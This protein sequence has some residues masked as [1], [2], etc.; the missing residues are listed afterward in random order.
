MHASSLFTV[1]PAKAGTQ[2]ERRA[3]ALGP[4][5]RGDDERER[6]TFPE[7]GVMQPAD[8]SL[9]RRQTRDRLITARMALGG[10]QRR[11][12]GGEIERRLAALLGGLAGRVVG[13]Y[14]P[15]RAEVDPRPLA[16][17]LWSQ[18]RTLALPAIVERHG[19]LE[20]RAWH[21]DAEMERGLYDIPAPKARDVVRPD[22]IVVPLVGFDAANYRLGYGGGYFDRT[23]A[24]LEPQPVTVGVGFEAALLDTIHPQPHDVAMDFI[25]TEARLRQRE[26][27]GV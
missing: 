20:Y 19:A 6:F 12:W 13:L 17:E 9:W 1:V 4:R 21:R 5:F 24:A 26:K 14:W 27:G 7:S 22:I 15:H 2:G 8:I 23:L 18:G 10:E 11:R 16:D 3:V 25:V